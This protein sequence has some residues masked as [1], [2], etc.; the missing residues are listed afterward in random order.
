VE[1]NEKG[2]R[3]MRRIYRRTKRNE[4]EKGEKY[5]LNNICIDHIAK[6]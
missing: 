5:K 6:Y 1:E 3:V 2:K 4:D